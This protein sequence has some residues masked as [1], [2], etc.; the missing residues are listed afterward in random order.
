MTTR[1]ATRKQ[2][3]L[4][5]LDA[6]DGEYHDL[7]PKGSIDAPI[8]TLIGEINS[9]GGLVTTSSCSGRIS[10]F[11]EGRKAV[12]NGSDTA[13]GNQDG[14]DAALDTE[15]SRAGPGGKGGGGAWLF[16]S[17]CPIPQAEETSPNYIPKF[18][19]EHSPCGK[20]TTSD[21]ATRRYIH[22]KFE[23]MILHILTASFQDAQVVLTAALSAGFRESGAVSLGC[24]KTGESNPMVAVRSTGYSFDSIIGYQN[25]QGRNIAIVDESCLETLVNIANER[26]NINQDRIA[27]FR[28]ALLAASQPTTSSPPGSSRPAWEDADMRKRRKREE[29]LARKHALHDQQGQKNSDDILDTLDGTIL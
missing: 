10:I 11:C 26:F 28:T 22:L 19:L 13:I 21:V 1:F 3:I 7:S 20:A 17:H 18:G 4:Q 24:T 25:D 14:H 15:D 16:I 6:P 29:G 23:P 12:Q 2:V 27:R 9:L 5:Q 8:R